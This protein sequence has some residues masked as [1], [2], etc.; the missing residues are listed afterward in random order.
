LLS[1]LEVIYLPSLYLVVSYFIL[2]LRF[3]WGP[4][5]LPN[6][7]PLSV[8]SGICFSPISKSLLGSNK[9]ATPLYK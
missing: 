4:S 7:I 9:F 3:V 2:F 5:K 6:F 8:T 1:R